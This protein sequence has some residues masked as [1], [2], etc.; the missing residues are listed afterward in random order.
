M[1]LKKEEKNWDLVTFINWDFWEFNPHTWI[2]YLRANQGILNWN[3]V[4]F[5]WWHL[6]LDEAIAN[7]GKIKVVKPTEKEE[8]I[9]FYHLEDTLPQKKRED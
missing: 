1:K 3:V 9:E 6:M 5:N 7:K 4:K 8:E 2:W